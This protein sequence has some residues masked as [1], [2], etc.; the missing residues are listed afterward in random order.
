MKY[1]KSIIIVFFIG[2]L[3]FPAKTLAQKQDCKGQFNLAEDFFIEGNFLQA[4]RLLEEYYECSRYRNSDYYKLKA[5][6][7]AD[8]KSKM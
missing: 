7:Y 8:I 6:L 4:E 5:E 2:L 3:V 1:Y